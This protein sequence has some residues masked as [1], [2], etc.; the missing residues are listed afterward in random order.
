[1][2]LS[3]HLDPSRHFVM[4]SAEGEVT[5]ADVEAYLSEIERSNA[6]S[7]RKLLDLRSARVALSADDVLAIGVRLREADASG[8][9]GALAVVMPEVDP[10]GLMRLLGFLAAAK[11]PMRLFKAIEPARRW[12]KSSRRARAAGAAAR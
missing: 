12:I 11:R 6:T 8:D 1:M 10:E 5:R 9:V 2:A 3:W 4:V 7:W